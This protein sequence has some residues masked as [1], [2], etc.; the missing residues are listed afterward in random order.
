MDDY[1]SGK[2]SEKPG[3]IH[4]NNVPR[5]LVEVLT[6]ATVGE[7]EEE[8]IEK[9]NMPKWDGSETK[10]VPDE[11]ANEYEDQYSGIKLEYV[12]T[13]DE[14]KNCIKKV[15]FKKGISVRNLV[16][17]VLLII[18]FVIFIISFFIYGGMLNLI[19]GTISLLVITSIWTIPKIILKNNTLS[20]LYDKNYFIE[21]YPD[22]II[23][24]KENNEKLLIPMDQTSEYEEF[25]DLIIVYTKDKKILPIPLRS[26]EPSVLG[27]VQAIIVTGC[28]PKEV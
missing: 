9:N 20:S 1:N 23:I 21:I 3:G 13:K 17:T 27:D 15:N 4:K 24:E 11:D 6:A 28:I 10:F 5:E 16:E 18:A 2:S 25:N 26:I 8:A 7:L 22:E 19:L 14:I 12:L